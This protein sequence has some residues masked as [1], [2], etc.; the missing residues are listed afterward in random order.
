MFGFSKVERRMA[1][2]EES[3]EKLEGQ[4][5]HVQLE[6][7]DA[8]DKLFRLM[9]R[10]AKRDAVD[11]RKQEE[12]AAAEPA[13]SGETPISSLTPRQRQI[14]ERI[15]QRRNRIPQLGTSKEQ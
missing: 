4:W 7:L 5:K 15:L 14:T 1:T 3:L 13:P 12:N 8:Y 9:Q 6:W 11:A 10:M 2:L